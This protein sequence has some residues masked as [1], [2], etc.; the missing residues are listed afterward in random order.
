[1][2]N[3]CGFVTI[4]LI[5]IVIIISVLATL[6]VPSIARI[7]DTAEVDYE[8]KTLLSEINSV[9]S[10]NRNVH[11]NPSIFKDKISGNAGHKLQINIDENLNRY[12]ITRNG[13]NFDEPHE[14]PQG[15]SITC[16][17]G[18]PNEII[19]GETYSGHIKINSRHNVK[20]YLICD[21]VGRWRGD[22]TPP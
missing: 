8:M 19:P 10:L 11:Y 14:L 12:I 2:K 9:Q 6:A 5:F 7:V 15:F 21:S 20:R 3:Q 17:K 22:I 16:E 13:E 4:E 18:L 1:M